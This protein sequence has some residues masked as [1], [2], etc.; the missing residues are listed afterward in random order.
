M[1]GGGRTCGAPLP[2]NTRKA[3]S[4]NYPDYYYQLSPATARAA[5]AAAAAKVEAGPTA[6]G[7]TAAGV[8]PLAVG[9]L[10]GD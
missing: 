4:E 7:V 6:A 2:Q 1:G 10:G 8:E 5:A 3:V 9:A